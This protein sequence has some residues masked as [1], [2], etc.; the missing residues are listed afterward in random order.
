MNGL[1]LKRNPDRAMGSGLQ[2]TALQAESD[3]SAARLPRANIL[4]VGIH[5]VGMKKAVEAV[6][7]AIAS[8]R[9]GYICV[10]NVHVVVEA[11]DRA[12]YRRLLNE[13]FLTVPDGRP[14]VWVG[15]LQGSRAIEQVGGPEIMIELCDRSRDR[16]YTHFFY[17]GAPGVAEQLKDVL[18]KRFPG[19]CVA[20]TYSPPYRPLHADEELM[21]KQLFARVKPDVTW[22]GLGAPKQERFMASY[23]PLLD[24]TIM[25]GV[26]AAFD[27][28]TGRIANSPGWVKACGAAWLFRLIQ[29]PS[30]LWK[31][32]LKTIPP[33]LWG[34]FLQIL[35]LKRYELMTL[36]PDTR[37]NSAL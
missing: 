1:P 5:A 17:G 11:Q 36:Q 15:R 19:L 25:I 29:E 28:H 4:G 2:L 13:S 16:G 21:L 3:S 31:R 30:R 26:G 6:E 12:D 27:I 37:N 18:T 7:G 33:F 34:V 8:R 20:G 23:L 22:V 14:L 10:A 35:G 9:K 32:Y 24:T